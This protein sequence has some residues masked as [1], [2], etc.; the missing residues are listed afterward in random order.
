[1]P[2]CSN[3]YY[4]ELHKLIHQPLLVGQDDANEPDD[5]HDLQVVEQTAPKI[6]HP[7]LYKAVLLNDD[8]TPM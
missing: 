8:Y 5:N 4:E 6:A 3:P 1:M 7:S 2:I